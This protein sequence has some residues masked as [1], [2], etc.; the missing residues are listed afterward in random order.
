MSIVIT[1]YPTT[2]NGGLVELHFL[3]FDLIHWIIRKKPEPMTYKNFTITK[4]LFECMS[5]GNHVSG[6]VIF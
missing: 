4:E 3:V 1:D 5:P 2:F 6:L